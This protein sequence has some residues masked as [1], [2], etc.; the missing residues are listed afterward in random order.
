[1]N[2]PPADG[3]WVVH[4]RRPGLDSIG[5][6]AHAIYDARRG[7]MASGGVVPCR[8]ELTLGAWFVWT[9]VASNGDINI[10]TTMF[11]RDL[12]MSLRWVAREHR[13]CSAAIRKG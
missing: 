11:L 1:M 2:R 10:E 3:K 7:G 9:V 5:R 4:P 13:G 12:V 8:C 6:S